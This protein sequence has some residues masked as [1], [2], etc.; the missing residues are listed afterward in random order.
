MFRHDFDEYEYGLVS[1]S[2]WNDIIDRATA[3]AWYSSLAMS[4][5]L[6]TFTGC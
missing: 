1:G 4:V 5:P 6:M 2:I 3:A